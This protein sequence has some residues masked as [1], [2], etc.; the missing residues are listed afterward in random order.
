LENI[1]QGDL[2]KCTPTLAMQ[3]NRRMI[4]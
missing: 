3:M 1:A 2:G 4:S